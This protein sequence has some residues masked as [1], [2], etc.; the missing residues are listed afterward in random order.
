MKLCKKK[1]VL[2]L[3]GKTISQKKKL[4]IK[5]L[6]LYLKHNKNV[7]FIEPGKKI[8]ETT[9]CFKN[10]SCYTLGNMTTEGLYEICSK[11]DL[12]VFL[13]ES[14]LPDFEKLVWLTKVFKRNY[15][16]FFKKESETDSFVSNFLENFR[17]FYME[18]KKWQLSKNK[19]ITTTK[20]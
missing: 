19:T 14:K 3:L 18:N 13:E 12:I 20:S 6:Y 4:N 1:E 15:L 11:N 9:E 5:I 10:I 16:N 7:A 17:D 8:A 2:C